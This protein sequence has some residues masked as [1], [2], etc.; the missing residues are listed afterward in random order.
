VEKLVYLIFQS[1]GASGDSLRDALLGEAVPRLQAAGATGLRVNVNDEALYA[2][3]PQVASDFRKGPPIR[4]MVSLWLDSA[5]SR[6]PLEESLASHAQ[7]LAGYLVAESC[8]LVHPVQPGERTPGFNQVTCINRRPDLEYDRFLEIWQ[9]DHRKVAIEIQATTGYVRNLIVRALTEGAPPF[10]AVVE[11]T[12]PIEALTDR[13][14]LYAHA[15]SDEVLEA[16]TAQMMAS[17]ERFLD[18]EPMEMTFMS[19]YVVR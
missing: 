3:E 19:E 11:E 14:V 10:D 9:Q 1:E 13:R 16:R 18:F 8:P 6:G 7:G 5:D 17:C 15:E 4:A 2:G 12:F